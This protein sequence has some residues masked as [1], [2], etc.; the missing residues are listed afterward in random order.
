MHLVDLIAQTS[1]TNNRVEDALGVVQTIIEYAGTAAYAISAAQ[2]AGRRRMNVVGVV[3]FSVLVAVGGGTSR[4]LLLGELPVFWVEDPTPLIVAAV[5]GAATIPLFRVGTISLI[6][7]YDLVRAFDA[8]GLAL[9][10]ILGTNIALDAGAGTISAV[11]VGTI[12]GI[13]GGIIRDSLADR[14]PAVLRSGHFYASVALTG[15][16]LDVALLETSL[17]PAYASTIAVSYIL[18]LRLLS[19]HLGWGVPKFEIDADGDGRPDTTVS[20]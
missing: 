4:D 15:A 17:S 6:Q 5:A 13:G 12:A 14:V 18:V 16:A 11:F 20:A 8:S 3:V 2:L 10:T 19:I 7:R 1:E 9:F